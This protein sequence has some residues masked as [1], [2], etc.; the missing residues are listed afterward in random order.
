MVI[1]S[2]LGVAALEQPFVAKPVVLVVE[3]DNVDE[4]FNCVAGQL[5][6]SEVAVFDGAVVEV[7]VEE[8][9]VE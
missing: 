9:V 7:I 6:D 5:L 8:V 4:Q 3:S 1:D 2:L